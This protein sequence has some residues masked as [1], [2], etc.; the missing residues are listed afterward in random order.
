MKIES[1][2][3]IYGIM[4][5]LC[6]LL[7]YLWLS[8][9]P[10]TLTSEGSQFATALFSAVNQKSE[11]RLAEISELLDSAL[12]EGSLTPEEAKQLHAIIDQAQ[13][14]DWDQALRRVR[15]LMLHQNRSQP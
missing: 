9:R 13:S 15:K 4:V 3:W 10:A 6:L 7:G 2:P 1:K 8:N 12:E 11:P 14:G 5:A